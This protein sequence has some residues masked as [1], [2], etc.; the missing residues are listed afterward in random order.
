MKTVITILLTALAIVGSYA[1]L[2]LADAESQVLVA[3][4]FSADLP[5]I[6]VTRYPSSSPAPVPMPTIPTPRLRVERFD[7]TLLVDV[8]PFDEHGLPRPAAFAEIAKA[9]RARTGDEKPIDPRLVEMLMMLSQAF[10][11]RPIALVSA[12]RIA[13][14]GTRKTSYHTKGLAAD[15]AIRGVRVHKLRKAAVR[16]GATGV[17][18][19]PS[20]VHVD[21]RRDRPAYRWVGGTYA[22]WGR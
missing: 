1:T 3:R 14:R 9:F 10:D 12:H 5:V 21:V 22:G 19:Y 4:S 17:G 11:G 16:L 18:V 15:I 13:G 7:G 2:V 6:D 8:Q 20:F